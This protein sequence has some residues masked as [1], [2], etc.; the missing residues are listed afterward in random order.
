MMGWFKRKSSKAE[1]H[2]KLDQEQV[3]EK[4]RTTPLLVVIGGKRLHQFTPG[5]TGKDHKYQFDDVSEEIER[6]GFARKAM[7]REDEAR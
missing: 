4:L 6:W 2:Q 3:P 5:L 1:R 7:E